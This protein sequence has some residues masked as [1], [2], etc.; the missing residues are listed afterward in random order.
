MWPNFGLKREEGWASVIRIGERIDLAHVIRSAGKLPEIR[1]SE[2]F[3]IDGTP[4]DA[5]ARLAQHKGLKRFRCASLLGESQY[6]VAQLEAPAVPPEERVQ[7][8]RWRLKDM[9]DFPV[10]AASVAVAD[11]PAEGS[12]QPSVFA[13]VAP[14]EVIAERMALFHEARVP[15]EAI[16]IPEMAVRNVAALFEEPNRG[17]A[18]LALNSGESLLTIT[19]AGELYLSRRIEVSSQALADADEERRQQMLERLALELQRTLDNFDRQYGFISVSRLLV[20]SEFD[21]ADTVSGLAHNLYLPVQV[22]DLAQVAE[23]TAVPELRSVERQA[24]CLLAIGAAL[25]SEA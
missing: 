17:L 5:L 6:R 25:R 4:R 23:F 11:I 12:R 21:C 1:I 18:F 13:I 10:D 8:L 19:Y 16:D 22:A 9:V 2:S 3:Q 14:R 15:L 24:Q 20:C 7:A